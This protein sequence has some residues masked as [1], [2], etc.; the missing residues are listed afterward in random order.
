M[1]IALAMVVSL[2]RS[3]T[4]DAMKSVLLALTV[5]AGS[6]LEL[7]A[8]QPILACEAS[9]MIRATAPADRSA[10]PVSGHWYINA[11]RSISATSGDHELRFVTMV[12]PP[13]P[14]RGR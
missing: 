10:D 6:Q 8:Q 4:G 9:P 11:D 12:E 2:T 3:C 7:D 13:A 1:R 5:V 14:P